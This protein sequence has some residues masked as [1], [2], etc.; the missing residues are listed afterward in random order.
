[1]QEALTAAQEAE[2]RDLGVQAI[3]AVAWADLLEVALTLVGSTL[4]PYSGANEFKIRDIIPSG[5]PPPPTSSTWLKKNGYE[6]SSVDLLRAASRAAA[7]HQDRARR[8][9]SILG[10]PCTLVSAYY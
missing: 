4:P 5:S 6:G 8:A 3:A 1:M 2:A 9:V 7:Y 10:Y